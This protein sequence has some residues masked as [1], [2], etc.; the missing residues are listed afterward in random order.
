M[1]L[2]GSL[3][4]IN[5]GVQ[6]KDAA[7]EIFRRIYYSKRHCTVENE[8]QLLDE[9]DDF[10]L[11]EESKELVTRALRKLIQTGSNVPFSFLCI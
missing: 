7:L 1:A 4:Q 9:M 2:R 6:D 11:E 8:K 5:L 3:P 10:K